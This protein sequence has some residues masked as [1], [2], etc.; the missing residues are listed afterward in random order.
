MSST[1]PMKDD[2]WILSETLRKTS[3]QPY[4][5]R[6]LQSTKSSSL[7]RQITQQTTFNSY[8]RAFTEEFSGNCRFIFTCNFKNKIIEPLHSR[9]AC[10]DFSTDR[11]S[12]PQLASTFFNRLKLY[13]REK[14]LNGSESS[15]RINQQTLS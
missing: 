7:M 12:K 9:C 8:L 15:Y 11:K 4:H 5:F 3:L 6:Q 1:D 2:S 14:V 10:I 13:L